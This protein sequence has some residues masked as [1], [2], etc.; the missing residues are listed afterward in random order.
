MKVDFANLLKDQATEVKWRYTESPE[1]EASTVPWPRKLWKLSPGLWRDMHWFISCVKGK[2]STWRTVFRHSR[3]C[4]VRVF[5]NEVESNLGSAALADLL[6]WFC[7]KEIDCDSS[8]FCTRM[9]VILY[10]K[11]GHYSCMICMYS[12]FAFL[13][14]FTLQFHKCMEL[15]EE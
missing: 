5:N 15:P 3:N 13:G 12:S 11:C 9:F 4:F 10:N 1:K 8:C 14:V 7:R 6:W 2:L